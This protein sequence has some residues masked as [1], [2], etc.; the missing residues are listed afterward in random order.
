MTAI[1]KYK[2][3]ALVQY[4]KAFKFGKGAMLQFL[5]SLKT[6]VSNEIPKWWLSF[7]QNYSTNI[8]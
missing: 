7:I 2:V 1:V 6:L 5:D 3:R 8:P 4:F